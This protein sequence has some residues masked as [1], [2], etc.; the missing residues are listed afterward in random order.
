MINGLH[1]SSDAVRQHLQ[2]TDKYQEQSKMEVYL[3]MLKL[4]ETAIRK[5]QN[6]VI[7]ATFYKADI[8]N[9]FKQK[10]ER[11]NSHSYFIEIRADESTI[12]DRVKKK[13]EESEADFAVYLKV[14]SVFEPLKEVHLTLYSDQEELD[15]MLDQ[16]LTYIHYPNGATGN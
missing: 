16:A 12:R 2:Q 14:K 8:R 11:L 15:H 13:R 6:T 3:E 10:A 7:D 9:L 5:Q 4:M 1:I